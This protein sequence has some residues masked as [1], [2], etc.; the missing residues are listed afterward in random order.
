MNWSSHLQ[1]SK[2]KLQR[3]GCEN[4]LDYH[5]WFDHHI[6]KIEEEKNCSCLV[7]KT[8][9]VF[10]L[11]WSSHLQKSK[12][13]CKRPGCEKL[14]TQMYRENNS[15]HIF[16]IKITINFL[17]NHLWWWIYVRFENC[18]IAIHSQSVLPQPSPPAKV[19]FNWE[20]GKIWDI[21]LSL[22]RPI[23]MITIHPTYSS[24]WT[25]KAR[26]L[27]GIAWYYMVLLGIAW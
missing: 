18:E 23:T 9:K 8:I 11:V 13:N 7:V 6:S 24:E 12:Q 19:R 4:F 27:Q 25:K 21:I 26:V 15:I 22:R 20:I 10:F 2:Q 1:N 16:N 14:R 3:P 5:F 17:L